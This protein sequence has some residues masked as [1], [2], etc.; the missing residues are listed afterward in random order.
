M[1][2][3]IFKQFTTTEKLRFLE[4]KNDILACGNKVEDL[5]TVR[6]MI[7]VIRHTRAK[8]GY[9]RDRNSAMCELFTEAMAPLFRVIGELDPERVRRARHQVRAAAD[10]AFEIAHHAAFAEFTP[11]EDDAA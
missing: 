2:T 1:T 9:E 7:R 8:V 4:L 3:C 5:N 6:D 10:R 11:Q